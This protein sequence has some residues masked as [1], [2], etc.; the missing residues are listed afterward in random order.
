MEQA[1]SRPAPGTGDQSKL[2]PEVAHEVEGYRRTVWQV[3]NSFIL[4][5]AQYPTD[6]VHLI[7]SR[8]G[9]NQDLDDARFNFFRRA[10]RPAS[11]TAK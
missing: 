3:P 2:P 6:P 10:V 4:A 11:R 5:M 1:Y 9:K 8:T 7:Y